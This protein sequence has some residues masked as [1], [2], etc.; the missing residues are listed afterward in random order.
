MSCLLIRWGP[1]NFPEAHKLNFRRHARKMAAYL[2]DLN[3]YSNPCKDHLSKLDQTLKQLVDA[4]LTLKMVK[5]QFAIEHCKYLGNRI[6]H[7]QQ[8]LQTSVIKAIQMFKVKRRK[9]D[10]RAFLSM[11]GYY[12]RFVKEYAA[13]AATL[14][15]M[16]RKAHPD[17]VKWREIHDKAFKM[18][19]AAF[20]C[21]SV[22]DGWDARI[23]TMKTDASDVGIGAVLSQEHGEHKYRS[24]ANFYRKVKNYATVERECLAKVEGTRHFQVYFTRVRFKVIR[25][26]GWQQYLT[27]I[28]DAGGRLIRWAL[29]LQVFDYTTPHCTG[30]DNGNA[31][32]LSRQA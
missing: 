8:H 13:I 11:T 9:K 12:R 28:K 23:F 1:G 6:R 15:D 2:D 30:Q 16:M 27:S 3:I 19:K 21:D 14:S 17:K 31:E 26:H 24:V 20:Q 7:G 32:S 4:V 10:I 18:L 5:C 25:E 22:Q 29:R